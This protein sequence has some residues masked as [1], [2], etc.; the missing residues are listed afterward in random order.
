MNIVL[1]GYRG[2][3][4]S[5][6]GKLVSERLRIKCITMDARIVEKAGKSIPDIVENH[7]WTTFRDMESEVATELAKLDNIIIDTGGGIIERPENIDV[8]QANSCI[9]WLKASVGVIVSRI[10]EG[11]ERPSLTGGKSFTEEVAEVLERRTPKYMSAAQY[12]IDTDQLTPEQVADR[13][14]KIWKKGDFTRST[15]GGHPARP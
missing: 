6:V 5:V 7:G 1:I 4:K 3:G 8:L 12:Q 14:I 13:I 9:I 2:S 15:Q 10:Q 11:T